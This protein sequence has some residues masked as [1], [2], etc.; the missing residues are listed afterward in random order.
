MIISA[1]PVLFM[2]FISVAG[3]GVAFSGFLP[4]ETR[5]PSILDRP[6]AIPLWGIIGQ[7][8][9]Q[10]L[11]AATGDFEFLVRATLRG[12][13]PQ[14]YLHARYLRSDSARR[15]RTPSQLPSL[16]FIST[17]VSTIFLVN[18]MIA[19]SA[20][21]RVASS[22]TA[23]HRTAQPRAAPRRIAPPRTTPPHPAPHRAALIA[24]QR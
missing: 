9:L 23:P 24:P 14:A 1:V 19:Q 20:L 2:M 5:V 16:L 15:R 11:N 4:L 7:I 22:R 13:E 8:D 12:A 18:L 17:F 21:Q 6:W 3:F 10:S